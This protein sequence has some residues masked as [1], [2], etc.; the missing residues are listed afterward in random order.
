[1]TDALE[2][3]TQ[4]Y[5]ALPDREFLI[6]I[7][8]MD[9]THLGELAQLDDSPDRIPRLAKRVAAIHQSNPSL[10]D[11]VAVRT[12]I[13]PTV[14]PWTNNLFKRENPTNG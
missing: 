3:E 10:Y 5:L 13:E 11:E 1:M 12:A 7:R 9:V 8:D 14:E 2:K 6:T 4:T